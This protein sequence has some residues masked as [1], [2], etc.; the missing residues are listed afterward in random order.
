MSPNYLEA[1]RIPITHGR[2]FTQQEWSDTGA[3]GRVAVINE[4]MAKKFWPDGDPI[5]KR[6]TFGSATDTNPR[7]FTIIG[8]AAD[9]KHRQLASPR[10]FQGYIPFRQSVNNTEVIVIPASGDPSRATA[11]TLAALRRSGGCDAVE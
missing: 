1:L 2:M 3:P 10:D 6:F 4:N 9:I 7:S 5:G 8:V 11:P